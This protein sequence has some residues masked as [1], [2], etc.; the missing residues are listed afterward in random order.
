MHYKNSLIGSNGVVEDATY[1]G[2]W[3]GGRRD[4]QGTITWVDGTSF[5]GTWRYDQRFEGEMRFNNGNSYEGKFLNDKLHG[6]ARVYLATG[7]IFEGNFDQ[8]QCDGVGKLLYPNGDIYF[9]Q[10]KGFGKDGQGKMLY[11][12]G[13]SYE[14][15]WSNERKNAQGLMR[16]TVTGD[17]YNG[18][19]TDGKKNGKGRYYTHEKQEIY[20]GD[21]SNDRRQGEGFMINRKGVVCSGDF[22][23][24]HM[25][26][27]L[28][29]WKT[30]SE[31]ETEDIF[32]V[33][34]DTNDQF[35]IVSNGQTHLPNGL[36]SKSE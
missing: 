27:K 35:I 5:T 14:G 23:A 36:P 10:H 25:E 4:G 33:M 19:Y 15:G 13:S 1:E 16:D 30:L 34:L 8:N 2:Y 32:S 31:S 21:W 18:Q 3:K 17:V 12:N 9:G 22:R 6:F 20:D 26:G 7:V 29:Y 28:T 24:D 11:A